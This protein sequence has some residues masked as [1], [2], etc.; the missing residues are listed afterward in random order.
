MDGNRLLWAGG[1][2]SRKAEVVIV[3]AVAFGV[4]NVRFNSVERP[5]HLSVA[6][7]AS[8]ISALVRSSFS[9]VS[10]SFHLILSSKM[11]SICPDLSRTMFCGAQPQKRRPRLFIIKRGER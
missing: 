7:H 10:F 9:E 1:Y 4:R 8:H 6:S 3:T 5:A 2:L 11:Y